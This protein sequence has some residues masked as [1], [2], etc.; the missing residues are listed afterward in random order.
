[1]ADFAVLTLLA[2]WCF[3]GFLLSMA[4][5]GNGVHEPITISKWM[6]WVWFGLDGTGIPRSVDFHWLL[7]P[8]LMVAFAFLGNTLFLT[9]L[10]SMLSN[11]FANIVSN[12]SAEIQFRRSV[13]TLEGV[14]S[15]S[16]F[17]YQPPFNIVAL[18][19][20]LPLKFIVSPRWFHKVNVFAIRVLNAPIL[21]IIS[22]LERRALWS[23]PR[24]ERGTLHRAKSATNIWD[25]SRGFSVHGDIQAV[26]D[27]A[28]LEDNGDDDVAISETDE[29]TVPEMEQSQELSVPKDGVTRPDLSRTQSKTG[30]MRSRSRRDSMAPFGG[31]KDQLK[32]M[33]N[34][35]D[36]N[37]DN[38]TRLQRLEKS[39]QRIEKLLERILVNS[40]EERKERIDEDGEVTPLDDLDQRLE[41]ERHE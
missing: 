32:D 24:R 30:S 41:A 36:D 26:F 38:D 1:M 11:T 17:S 8:M 12:A 35:D 23:R 29:V 28:P 13:L 37:E 5:L 7:G 4:W 34:E 22:Y 39:I 18:F 16:I 9:I 40:E 31:L 19:I 3:A 33:L 14:K 10:V 15:D 21:L 6:L 25:L 20:L 27:S 2:V